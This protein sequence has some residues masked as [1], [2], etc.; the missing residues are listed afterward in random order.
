MREKTYE[1]EKYPTF[2]LSDLDH[3]KRL[4]PVKRKHAEESLKVS[5]EIE[6]TQ[7]AGHSGRVVKKSK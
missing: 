7:D 6:G 5:K 2:E 3:L 1:T 4:T